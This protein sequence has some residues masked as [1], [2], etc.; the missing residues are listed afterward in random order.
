MQYLFR[1]NGS[2][3]PRAASFRGRAEVRHARACDER[4]A[5]RSSKPRGRAGCFDAQKK[6]YAETTASKGLRTTQNLK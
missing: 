6:R 2:L 1:S 3:E 4:D 5:S